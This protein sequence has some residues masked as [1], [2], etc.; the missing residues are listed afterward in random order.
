MAVA[1]ITIETCPICPHWPLTSHLIPSSFMALSILA[2]FKA[3]SF[4]INANR[5]ENTG[6]PDNISSASPLFNPSGCQNLQRRDL[7]WPLSVNT[8]DHTLLLMAGRLTCDRPPAKK[9]LVLW[10]TTWP[11]HAHMHTRCAHTNP[12]QMWLFWASSKSLRRPFMSSGECPIKAFI[13]SFRT[14]LCNKQLET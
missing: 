11:E 9:S 14:D 10:S 2:T 12:K 4:H 5:M 6:G 13:S 8:P 3:N 1:A 7:S